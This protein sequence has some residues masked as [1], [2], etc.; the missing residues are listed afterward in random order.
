MKE[1]FT[2]GDLYVSDFIKPKDSPRGDQIEMKL[3]LDEKTGLVK[4]EKAA[5]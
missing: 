3:M 2:L 5:P 4:L 1:L